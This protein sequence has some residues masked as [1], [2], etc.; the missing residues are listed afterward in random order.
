[1]Y[2]QAVPLTDG[3][4]DLYGVEEGEEGG[5]HPKGSSGA[6]TGGTVTGGS[7]GQGQGQEKA[8]AAAGGGG[9]AGQ[10]APAPK[11]V[12]ATANGG[13][14]V[15]MSLAAAKP[16]A[17]AP[18]K[19]A[20]KVRRGTL[21]RRGTHAKH[22]PTVV[23][24]ARVAAS[25]SPLAGRPCPICPACTLWPC[26][27]GRVALGARAG[28]WR[29]VPAATYA[30]AAPSP[31]PNL[32]PVRCVPVLPADVACGW[33]LAHRAPASSASIH[34]ATCNGKGHVDQSNMTGV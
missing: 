2:V 20:A 13:A 29:R 9:A 33:R 4:V 22:A 18:A 17:A 12:A 14:S 15:S 19:A 21:P 8:K 26:C 24:R 3:A 6:A 5:Q 16:E 28:S 32:S 11:A 7:A 27:V 1:M 23:P 10:G 31:S 34:P 30:A 25:P